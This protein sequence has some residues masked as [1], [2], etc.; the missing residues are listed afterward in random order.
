MN[1]QNIQKKCDKNYQHELISTQGN[2]KSEQFHSCILSEVSLLIYISDKSTLLCAT[3]SILN[4]VM[5][6][7]YGMNELYIL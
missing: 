1:F 5:E 6:R 3:N 2:T 4:N 7:D